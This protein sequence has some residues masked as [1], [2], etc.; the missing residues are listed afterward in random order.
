[1]TQTL[2]CSVGRF[3]YAVMTFCD[4]ESAAATLVRFGFWPCSPVRPSTAFS[5]DLL[6]MMHMLTLECAVSVKGFVNTLRW[7]NNLTNYEVSSSM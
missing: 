5:I 6:K 7:L 4:H 1:M 2:C 3:H